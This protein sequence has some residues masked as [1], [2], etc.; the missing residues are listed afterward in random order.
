MAGEARVG[1][2]KEEAMNALTRW[3]SGPILREELD[4]LFSR[5]GDEALSPFSP[6]D[7]APALDVSELDNE[8][9]VKAEC[10]GMEAKDL[11]VR[12]ENDVLT[13]EGEK[14]NEIE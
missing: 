10:P 6:A 11:Q 4:R 3:S 2:R 12:I 1:R 9:I 8:Y 5:F 14:K 13:I 7:W